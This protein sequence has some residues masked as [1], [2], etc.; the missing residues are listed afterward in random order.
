MEYW[1][2]LL[3]EKSWNI[4]KDLQ[5]KP[6]HFIVIGGWAAYLWTKLH[7]S[8]DIDIIIPDFED[9]EYLK[10]AYD[11]KKNDHLKKYEIRF[12][13]IDVAIY[14]PYYSQLPLPITEIKKYTTIIENISVVTPEVLLILKQAAEQDREYSVK[15]AKDRVDI[16]TLLLFSTMNFQ[17]YKDLLKKHKLEHFQK[18]LERIINTFTDL[19]YLE[20]N[21]RTYKIKKK[22]LAQLLRKG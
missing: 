15:G 5:K 19:K 22:V 13:E 7:K 14:I 1:N 11:L 2:S 20:L 9:L 4:L 8:K 17:T 12:E 6:F 16:M 10:R 3:T 18:R 21:P